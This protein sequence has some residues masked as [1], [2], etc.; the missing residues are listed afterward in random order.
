MICFFL[1]VCSICGV[2]FYYVD[3]AMLEAAFHTV[4]SEIVCHNIAYTDMNIT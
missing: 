3:G 1:F 2:Y 4:Y